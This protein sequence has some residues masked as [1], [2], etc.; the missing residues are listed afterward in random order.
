MRRA[1]TALPFAGA[2]A[3]AVLVTIG[4]S[5]LGRA[6]MPSAA[7]PL[8]DGWHRERAPA[9]IPGAGTYDVALPPAMEKVPVTGTQSYVAEYRSGR[10]T[11][12]F[13]FGAR[14]RAPSPSCRGRSR[15]AIGAIEV[16]GRRASRLRYYEPDSD[17]G[18]PYRSAY[19]IPLAVLPGAAPRRITL[20]I[21]AE[22]ADASACD[23]ADRIVKTIEILPDR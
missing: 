2:A 7:T 12:L 19:A 4:A 11:L 20:T 17:G 13:E 8:P 15:C 9:S 18:L 10:L 16:G 3:F 14:R 21:R 1:E 5:A 22:C 6:A 23:L